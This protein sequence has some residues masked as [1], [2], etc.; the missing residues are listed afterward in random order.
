MA[1][2]TIAL[3]TGG[4]DCP[5]LN[6]VIRAAVRCAILKYGWKVYGIEDGFDG[7]RRSGV[8]LPSRR[9]GRLGLAAAA[10]VLAA[11][12]AAGIVVGAGGA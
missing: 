9:G 12:T 1:P 7:L 6:A 3:S 2:K 8:S 11:A 4:G 10:V 5:G